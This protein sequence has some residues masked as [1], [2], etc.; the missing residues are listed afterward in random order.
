[1]RKIKNLIA[2]ATLAIMALGSAVSPV[3]AEECC[4]PQDCY[5]TDAGGMGYECSQDCPSLAPYIV[6]GVVVV[7]AIVAIAVRHH[8]GSHNHG[9][10]H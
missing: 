1:M 3:H 10:C 6:L 2:S 8:H 7:A 9:H 5:A 4:P